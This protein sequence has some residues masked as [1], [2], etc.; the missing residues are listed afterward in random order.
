MFQTTNQ[1]NSQFLAPRFVNVDTVPIAIVPN[2]FLHS[3][4]GSLKSHNKWLL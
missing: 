4:S 1:L 2:R 3:P